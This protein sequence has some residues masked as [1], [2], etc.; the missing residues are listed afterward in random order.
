[1]YY[2]LEFKEKF[3]KKSQAEVYINMLEEDGW[4]PDHFEIVE[5]S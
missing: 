1:M 2:R 3:T 4:N 5:V